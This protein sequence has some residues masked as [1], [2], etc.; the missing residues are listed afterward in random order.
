M[1]LICSGYP[2]TP[3]TKRKTEN[4]TCVSVHAGA[5]AQQQQERA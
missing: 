5:A 2:S 3:T 4:I 1:A